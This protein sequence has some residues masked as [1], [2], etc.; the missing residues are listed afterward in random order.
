MALCTITIKP[1]L[2]R[3]KP[4]VIGNVCGNLSCCRIR[5]M[6]KIH[7]AYQRHAMES[8][9]LWVTHTAYLRHATKRL[10]IILPIR[11]P[12]GIFYPWWWRS[13][14][15][16]HV[17]LGTN[18]WVAR[19]CA[20]AILCR[21]VQAMH[22]I[23]SADLRHATKWSAIIS[24]IRKPIE[25]IYPWRLRVDHDKPCPVR[26]KPVALPNAYI[27]SRFLA[28]PKMTKTIKPCPVRDKP[29][30]SEDMRESPWCR[31]EKAGD[32]P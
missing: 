14:T 23:H 9:A 20:A 13:I 28:Y 8:S 4:M 31:P 5:A 27:R 12:Y 19:I 24:P 10:A 26:D 16:N 2:W 30:G 6:H 22:K 7:R 3:D 21:Q 1:C 17:Q 25:I 18:L 29:M 32:N 11:K 15:I